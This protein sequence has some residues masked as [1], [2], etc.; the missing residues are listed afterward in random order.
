MRALCSTIFQDAWSEVDEQPSILSTRERSPY[1]VARATLPRSNS[2]DSRHISSSVPRAPEN[3]TE[4]AEDRIFVS[5]VWKVLLGRPRKGNVVLFGFIHKHTRENIKLRRVLSM[6]NQRTGNKILV[7]IM[8]TFAR[9]AI[10]MSRPAH[11]GTSAVE[12]G[13]GQGQL[14]GIGR[15]FNSSLLTTPTAAIV[16]SDIATRDIFGFS[17]YEEG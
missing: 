3:A 1:G 13:S 16:M 5:D 6:H 2:R 7:E 4:Y 8:S 11:T 12:S 17:V 9:K 15:P 10:P 14:H